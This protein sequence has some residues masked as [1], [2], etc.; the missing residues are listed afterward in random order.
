[1]HYPERYDFVSTWC[2]CVFAHTRGKK[3][4]GGGCETDGRDG[5]EVKEKERN[6]TRNGNRDAPR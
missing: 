3:R 4:G 6:V 1:M 5:E 2:A